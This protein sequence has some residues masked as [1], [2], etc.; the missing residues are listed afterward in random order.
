MLS[1]MQLNRGVK[2]GEVTFLATMKGG[3]VSADGEVPKEVLEV[4]DART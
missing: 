4:L 1:A 3:E 2:K